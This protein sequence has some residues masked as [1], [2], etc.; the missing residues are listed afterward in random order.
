MSNIK[1]LDCTLRDGGYINNWN[2]GQQNI[3]GIIENLTR[4][5][6]DIIECGFIRNTEQN[7]DSSLFSSM[8][9]FEKIIAP[10]CKKVLYAIMIAT[11]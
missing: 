5:K 3:K 2:F 4:A 9:D 10:K 1:V 7:V 6:I 8:L 11:T